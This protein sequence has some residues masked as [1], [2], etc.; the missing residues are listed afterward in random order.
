MAHSFAAEDFHLLPIHQLAGRSGIASADI[1]SGT[2]AVRSLHGHIA[3]NLV[4]NDPH[5]LMNNRPIIVC[6]SDY[7]NAT[8]DAVAMWNKHLRGQEG[9]IPD[10][11]TDADT[12]NDREPFIEADAF[13]VDA[14]PT[15]ASSTDKIDYVSITSVDAASFRCDSSATAFGCFRVPSRSGRPLYTYYGHLKIEMNDGRRPKDD[16]RIDDLADDDYKG[17]VRTIAHEL[18]HVLGLDDYDCDSTRPVDSLME[19]SG[20]AI[21]AFTDWAYP[22]QEQDFD[23][24]AALYKPNLVAQ[25]DSRLFAEQRGSTVTFNLNLLDVN[26]EHTIEI[27][28]KVGGSWGSKTPLATLTAGHGKI[29]HRLR[30][31]PGGR[32]IYGIFSTTHA[33]LEGQ[34]SIE[35][36][37][38]GS[39]GAMR[40]KW[41]GFPREVPVEGKLAQPLTGFAYTPSTITFGDTGPALTAPTGAVGALSYRSSPPSVCTVG[42]T[43]GALTIVAAGSC[44]VTVTAA[45][46]STHLAGSA[47]ATVTIAKASQPLTGFAYTPSSITFGDADTALTAPSGAVGALSYSA[48]PPSVCTVGPTSGALTIVAA[49]SC[50]VTVTAASTSTHLAGSATATVTIAKASQPL[51]G[52]AYTPSSITFGDADTALTA[53]SGAVGALSYSASPPSVCTVGPTSGA[54]TIVAAGSCRVTVTAASTSTHLAGS[55]TAT[56]TIAKASQPLTGFAYTPSSITFGDADTALTA[57]SGAVGALSYSASPPSVCTVGPTSGA[58]TIVAAGS[59]RVTVTAA[60]TSTHLAG[61]ATATVTI[62]KASQPLTGFA[63]TPSSITFGDAD[64]ALT[65]PS[66]AVGALSYS[67]SP[68]SVCTV[69]PTSGALTIVAAG[70]CRVTVTAASTS[71]HLAGSATATVTIAKASQPLTGFAYT[72]STITFGDTGPALTA[73][74]GA[75]GALSYRSS[76]PSV[77]T[78]GPT[79][80]ALDIN[81]AGTCTVTV[82]AASTRTHLAGSATAMVTVNPPPPPPGPVCTVWGY[83]WSGTPPSGLPIGGYT[84]GGFTSSSA[85]QVS[86]D[87]TFEVLAP[88]G[89]TDLD[90]AVH[91]FTQVPPPSPAQITITLAAG[92]N[93]NIVWRGAVLPTDSISTSLPTFQAAWWLNP[94]TNVWHVYI[95]GAPAFVNAQHPV[96]QLRTGLTYSIKVS[97]AST[98]V[99]DAAHG[100]SAAAQGAQGAS[101]GGAPREGAAPN[102]AWTATV[103]CDAG[104]GP[105][106]LTAPTEQEAIQAASWLIRAPAGCGGAGSYT[107]SAPASG[108]PAQG[109]S[110]SAWTVTV[111]CDADP[112]PLRFSAPTREEAVTAANW[113]INLRE[114]CDGA[115]TYTTSPPTA[116][117]Q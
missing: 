26:V 14:C 11:K 8:R 93:N 94:A 3:R 109:A 53:P 62:A 47:T 106:A 41:I 9:Y 52:F 87:A 71:T 68:P 103:T 35:V 60:S 21:K 39:P 113:L 67:A 72:P 51:T 73:P 25:Y 5:V 54:L 83:S 58:L 16:D 31:Q 17:L 6:T 33:Y 28:R 29:T 27:R 97:A 91:C 2:I 85:A 15:S 7:A 4:I 114:G 49:G 13:K 34:E 19:C 105:V 112:A 98:W 38:A 50:R 84:G 116:S 77:C 117:G 104:P 70:S 101:A 12:T 66:G 108:A 65:A 110:D 56:V 86:L 61:S 55:A 78:V 37:D 100:V 23:D 45:S 115:G 107:T 92:V 79:S 59:C 18:G 32:K 1:K 40:T 80:G 36:Q 95:H 69:G 48:S 44:R 46:T 99:V 74:T 89:Y 20:L 75:V 96:A 102:S 111:T 64:T 76:P 10:S 30:D 57:P 88:I 24:Y 43:S 22:L 81:S 63:Y 90:G 42:P 82:R